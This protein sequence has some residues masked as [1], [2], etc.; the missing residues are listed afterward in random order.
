MHVYLLFSCLLLALLLAQQPLQAAPRLVASIKP[1]HSL[2][3]NITQGVTEPVLLMATNQSPH[4]YSL[5]PSERRML[6]NAELVFWIG[7][8]MEAFMP[9]L[10]ESMQDKTVVVSL[11]QSS[12]LI[13][14]PLRSR[15]QDE[16]NHNHETALHDPHIWLNTHNLESMADVIATRLIDIDPEHAA[17]YSN[18][19]H[20]LK[21]RINELRHTLHQQLADRVQP[22]LTFHDAYQYFER[23]FGLNNAG[24][25]SIDSEIQ[26]GARHIRHLK[27]QMKQKNIRCVFYEAP[28][29]PP[30]MKVIIAGV[31]ARAVA[32]DA[33]G[34]MQNAGSDNL[35]QTMMSLGQ[36][37]S[38]CLQAE[39]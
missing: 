29:E 14:H 28:I 10:I 15:D 19:H 21:I 9:R 18:N 38:D 33:T 11:M 39:K 22:F 26:P 34:T 30:M 20:K 23:E 27:N 25:V 2:V 24:F 31:N 12:D 36:S 7:P 8:G 13:L 37:F 17:Q 16:Q 6:E 5:R 4:H 32:L 3:S 35:F 1:V